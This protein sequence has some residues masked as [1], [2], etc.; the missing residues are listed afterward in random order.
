MNIALFSDT[1]LPD[2]NGVATSTYILRNELVKHGHNV[3]VVTTTIPTNVDYIDK[4]EN[5]LRL[6]G[7][8]LKK[9]YGYRASNIYSF[10]GM[11]EIKDFNPDIIHIQTEFG[12]GIFGKIT[13]EILN[14]PVIYTYHTMWSDYSHY[15]VPEGFKLADNVAKKVIEKISKIY[16]DSCSALIVPSQKTADILKNYGI[17]NKMNVIATGL[18][19]EQFDKNKEN[20]ELTQQIKDEY[21]LHDKFVVTFLGRIANEKSID[22]LIEAFKDIH[23]QYKNIVLMIVGGGPQLEELIEMVK[24]YELDDC[25]YFTGP[26]ESY[27]VPSYYHVSHLFVSASLSETQ[28]LTFIE[29]MASNVPVLARYDKNL[30]GVVLDGINGYFFNTKDELIEK[31]ITLSQ[32]NL[33]DLCKNAVNE[34]KKYSSENF[35]N[36]IIHLYQKVSNQ[37]HYIYKVISIRKEKNNSSVVTF[38][39]DKHTIDLILSDNVIQRYGLSIDKVMDREELEALKDQEKVAMAYK[40]AIKYLTYKDYTYAKLRSK[41]ESKMIYDDIQI[42]MT[43][44]LLMQKGLIDDKAYTEHYFQKAVKLGIGVTKIV[45][46]LKNEGISPYIIDEYLSEYSN[47]LEYDKAIEIITK[48]YNENKTKPTQAL[49]QAVRNK[50]FIKGF[51]KNIVEDAI[52]NFD[53]TMPKEHTRQLLIK[54]YNRV[55]HRY[56]NRYDKRVLKSKIIT[57][58]VQKGYEYDDVIE[59]IS[60]LWED[61]NS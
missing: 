49:I 16:S 57:F 17:Q 37:H 9:L 24:Q 6:P 5:I 36:K 61:N 42:E 13:G 4:D 50:L 33:V 41:L 32:T 52:N 58:L 54:E 47:D 31:I 40:D 8:D 10:K 59:V 55:L 30:E 7:L 51:S 35:Y 12:I 26:K 56:Q 44:D 18:P 20:K 27:L 53:F 34:A 38:K 28:G 60:E 48:L 2:I 23:K 3:L 45:Y 1:Y 21:N 46:N 15:L 14:K 43:M 29:A 19:L 39:V 22:L 11:K 25:I